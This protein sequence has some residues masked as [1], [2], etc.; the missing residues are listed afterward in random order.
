MSK[1]HICTQ[2]LQG[3]ALFSG[4]DFTAGKKNYTTASRDGREKFQ[5]YPL[6]QPTIVYVLVLVLVCTC[7]CPNSKRTCSN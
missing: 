7:T 5:V 4:K 1:F 2:I 6:L 3:N